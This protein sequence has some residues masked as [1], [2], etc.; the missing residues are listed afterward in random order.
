MIT[1]VLAHNIVENVDF[2]Q[3]KPCK[4]NE[5]YVLKNVMQNNT[6]IHTRLHTVTVTFFSLLAGKSEW[7][8]V[9][10]KSQQGT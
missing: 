2:T 9:I 6:Y 1:I 8:I 4:L 7:N 3:I 10:N 5:A